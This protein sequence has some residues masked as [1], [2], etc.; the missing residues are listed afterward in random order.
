MSWIT[1]V[2]LT[3]FG[4]LEG[5]T[6]LDLMSEAASAALGDAGLERREV[7]GVLCGY[8]TTLPHLMLATLF[9]SISA[10]SRAMRTA[11]R[12]A[13]PRASPW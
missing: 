7:D 6:T 9:S 1:G 13:V 11:C 4:R 10:S 5:R 8:S 2:G 3:A 12:R